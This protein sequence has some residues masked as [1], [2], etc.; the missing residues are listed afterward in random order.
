MVVKKFYKK[1]GIY[2]DWA[3]LKKL[4][5]IDTLIDIGVGPTGTIDLYRHFKKAKL[6]LIDPL[7]EA[8]KFSEKLKKKRKLTFFQYA[9]GKDNDIKLQMKIQKKIGLSSLLKISKFNIQQKVIR[10][11]IVTIKKLDTIIKDTKKLK[12][13]GIKIDT[14][15]YEF[16]VILGASKVLKNTKFVIAEVRHN[17]ESLKNVYKL[18][19]F[20]DL[21]NRNNFILT[22]I[23][24]AKPF[25]ADLCFQPQKDLIK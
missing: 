17:H 5:Q 12:R 24:S 14:E 4:P 16:D 1:T 21:M 15:G 9:V 7:E 23:L 18:Y 19:E 8:K 13:I 22:M 2:T 3:Q 25:I 10:K 6:I 11:D 20:I